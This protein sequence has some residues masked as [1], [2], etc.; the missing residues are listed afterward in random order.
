MNKKRLVLVLVIPMVIATS[1]MI[2]ATKGASQ[3]VDADGRIVEISHEQ[4]VDSGGSAEITVKTSNSAGTTIIVEPEGFQVELSGSDGRIEDNRVRFL[5]VSN[6]DSAHTVEVNI[7]GG[8]N[9]DT[10][11]ITAW[12]NAGDRAD[13]TDVS[14]STIE[15]KGSETN[16]D[17][18]DDGDS[19]E[20]KSTDETEGSTNTT[21]EEE[22]LVENNTSA[23]NNSLNESNNQQ[24]NYNSESNRSTTKR[25]EKN[26][27]TNNTNNSNEPDE[28]TGNSVPG[29]GF[30]ASLAAFAGCGYAIISWYRIKAKN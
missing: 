24:R 20:D 14:M 29:F 13:A 28:D 4:T 27:E 9:G 21:Y 5:D 30:F 26:S 3:P 17:E 23:N 2:G 10:A 12:V 18:S 15:I 25:L 19:L 16:S 7:I 11:E 8:E 22:N 1:G 6:G